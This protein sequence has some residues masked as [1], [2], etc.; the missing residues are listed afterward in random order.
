MRTSIFQA[1]SFSESLNSIKP[2]QYNSLRKSTRMNHIFTIFIVL[3]GLAE[4]RAYNPGVSMHAIEETDTNVNTTGNRK[5]TFLLLASFQKKGIIKSMNNTTCIV[6]HIFVY[7]NSSEKEF[8]I[9]IK[10]LLF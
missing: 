2:N 8:S 9:A 4:L 10:G 1:G 6:N 5:Y 7:V 3:A